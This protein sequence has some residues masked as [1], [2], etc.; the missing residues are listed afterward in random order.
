MQSQ[1]LVADIN[2]F[3]VICLIFTLHMFSELPTSP[4][5]TFPESQSPKKDHTNINC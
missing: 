4:K 1:D 3:F 2:R 5:D